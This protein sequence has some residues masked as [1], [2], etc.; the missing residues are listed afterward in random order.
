MTRQR[1]DGE[2]FGA[3]GGAMAAIL[4]AGLL[5]GVRGEISQANAALVLVLVVTAAA[6]VGGRFAA[7]STALA[8]AVSFD[9]FLT[10]PYGLLAI[11]SW[12]DVWTTGLLLVVGLAVGQ[13]A[14]G[15]SSAVA[16]HRSV[17]DELGAVHRVSQ[18]AADGA[19]MGDLIDAVQAAEVAVLR[20]AD[21]T[22]QLLP[23][24]PALPVLEPSGRV[25]AP[26]VHVGEG[27]A[28]PSGG[29][30]IEV[31]GDGRTVGWLVGLPQPG[32]VGV[33]R[34]RRRAGIV[35]ANQLGLA[36]ARSGGPVPDA[37]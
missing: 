7:C 18:L 29:V 31:R 32:P 20:L 24:E 4:V 35:L 22:F 33:S 16:D 23:P 37:G 1:S 8:A 28:L 25:D 19:S 3:A 11:K 15:R 10:K 5:G 21:C 17:A 36:L 27:F 26:H 6:V 14:R 12:S 13:I 30:A 2:V 34:E 9:F